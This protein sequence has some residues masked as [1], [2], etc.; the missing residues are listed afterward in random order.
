MSNVVLLNRGVRTWHLKDGKDEKGNVIKR[1]LKPGGSIEC[2][3]AAEAEHLLGYKEIVDAEKA[4]P[5]I[6]DKVKALTAERDELKA[7]VA[8]LTAKLA[9]YEKAK[10]AEVPAGEK[11][12]KPKK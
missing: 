9:M 4:I 1:V 8:D 10:E 11:S 2:I 6:T 3:D 7:T 5:V 12:P